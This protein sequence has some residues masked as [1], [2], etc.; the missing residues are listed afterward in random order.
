[1]TEKE[2]M[3]AGELYDPSDAELVRLRQTAHSLCRQ[4]NNLDGTDALPSEILARC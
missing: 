1:M 3:L 4:Y 2:K